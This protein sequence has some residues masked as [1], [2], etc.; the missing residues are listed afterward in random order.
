MSTVICDWFILTNICV[1]LY[2][3]VNVDMI[4]GFD[5]VYDC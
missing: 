3:C 2:V 5:R 1:R 4:Y